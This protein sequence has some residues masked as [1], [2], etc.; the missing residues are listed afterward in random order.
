MSHAFEHRLETELEQFIRD[1]VYK[2][3]NFLDSPQAARVRMEGRGEVI[4]L[5]SNNYLG[6]SDEPEVVAAG[7][8][9]L[10]RWGAG[11]AS[12]R[13]ICGTYT[14]HRDARGGVRPPRRHG[15]VAQLRE[16]LER[17]RGRARDPAGRAGHRHQ[18]P[19]QSCVDHR[20]RPP[21]QG[22]H[23]VPDRRL[24]ARRPGRPRRQ[25]D[26][27]QGPSHPAGDHRRR[28]LDGRVDRPAARP[29]RAVPAAR[30]RVDGRRLARHRRPRRARP[31]HGRAF[32]SGRRGR[33]HHVD[34]RQGA[35]R[36]GRRIRRGVGRGV[37]L[38][39][40]ARA[41]TALLQRVAAH[42]GGQRA[43]QRRIS[44][45]PPRTGRHASHQRALFPRTAARARL[46]APARARPRSFRSS[47]ARRPRRSR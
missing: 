19:A 45:G 40:P 42:R 14:V 26:R 21:R 43:R 28:V 37:R 15:R 4:I 5:S 2:R 41:T 10:D 18:R 44:R 9:A 3:L 7:K 23:E 20:R 30:R 27:G 46:Q 25:V 16:R 34:A 47:S 12:V 33:H 6:L 35:R 8:A 32:R 1:G 17:Q 13:F 39:D 29:D 36:G 31:R 24:Q 38:P 22:D 11:T